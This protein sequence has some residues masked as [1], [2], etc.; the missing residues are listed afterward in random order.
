M[1]LNIFLF[2]TDAPNKLGNIAVGQKFLPMA[3]TLAYSA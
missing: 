1:S 3:N 2:I